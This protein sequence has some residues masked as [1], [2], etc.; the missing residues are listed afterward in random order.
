MVFRA[1]VKVAPI[2]F[3]IDVNDVVPLSVCRRWFDEIGLQKGLYELIG[4]PLEFGLNT[5]WDFRLFRFGWRIEPLLLGWHYS[6]L[7]ARN[8]GQS[9]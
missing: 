8:C 5:I 2:P 4:S 6:P 7:I 3:G 1:V 9:S